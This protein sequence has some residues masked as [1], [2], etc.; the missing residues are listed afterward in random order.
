MI[1]NGFVLYVAS[2]SQSI[3][4]YS[5]LLQQSPTRQSDDFALF[6]TPAGQA[7]RLWQQ[8]RV[9]PATEASAGGVEIVLSVDSIAELEAQ[10]LRWQS[11]GLEPIQTIETL[12]FG[13]TFTMI[14]SDGHRVRLMRLSV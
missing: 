13:E 2:L 7:L 3:C 11:L 8:D 9:I 6:M 14:D 10:W 1:L 4:L 5:E 12:S